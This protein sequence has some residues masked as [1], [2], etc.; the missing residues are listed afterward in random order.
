MSA[1]QLVDLNS[2]TLP[3]TRTKIHELLTRIDSTKLNTRQLKELR[4]FN[5]EFIKE[6]NS[7]YALD[8]LGKGLSKKKVFPLRGRKKRYDLFFYKDSL[9]NISV[10]GLFGG[11]AVASSNDFGA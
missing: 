7:Y 8:Y 11:E 10:N 6:D 9:F 5:Q 4:F 3:L 2:V 1:I